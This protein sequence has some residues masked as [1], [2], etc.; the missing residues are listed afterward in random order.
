MYVSAQNTL[1]PA[2]TASDRTFTVSRLSFVLVALFV[3]LLPGRPLADLRFTEATGRAVIVHEDAKLEARMLALEDELYLAALQGGAR[4]DGFSAVSAD[5]SLS[6]H[7]VI[8][9]ASMIMDYAIINEFEDD[10]HYSVTIR[11]VIG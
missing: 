1:A 9:P 3:F 8:R 11:A 7:F 6:D 2:Q 4:I 10:T 5:T